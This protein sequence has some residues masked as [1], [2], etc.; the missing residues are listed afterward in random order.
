MSK[1][2]DQHTLN[3]FGDDPRKRPLPPGGI[4]TRL[5]GVRRIQGAQARI[6]RMKRVGVV[7][8]VVSREPHNAYDPNAIALLAPGNA[9]VERRLVGYLDRELAAALAPVVDARPGR[10][11]CRVE[12]VTGGDDGKFFGVNVAL[13]YDDGFDLL[14]YHPR[15]R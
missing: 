4:Y 15:Y 10:L 8:L 1:R 14:P 13:F 7:Y 11:R 12:Q 6:G 5:V 2:A 3:I 9:P